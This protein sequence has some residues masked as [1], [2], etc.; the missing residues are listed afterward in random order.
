[1]TPTD[2]ELK[3]LVAS[4]SQQPYEKPSIE[5]IRR[6]AVRRKTRRASAKVALPIALIALSG[7]AIVPLW[8]GFRHGH[9]GASTPT[10]SSVAPYVPSGL[11][12]LF[13]HP[14]GTTGI[15]TLYLMHAGGSPEDTHIPE[16]HIPTV[17]PDGTKAVIAKGISEGRSELLIVDLK[18]GK[19]TLLT[20]ADNPQAASWSPS[21]NLIAVSAGSGG[22]V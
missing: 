19:E 18:T 15:D 2:E 6:R 12:L 22:S 20:D 1:M 4:L 14:A 10:V 7:L 5:R 13:A 3:A 21:G 17:S 9:S 11:F 8:S 16:G